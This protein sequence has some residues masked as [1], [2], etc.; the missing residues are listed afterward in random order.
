MTIFNASYHLSAIS[1]HTKMSL[2]KRK[3]NKVTLVLG[4][5]SARGIAHIGVLE[6]LHREGMHFDLIIGTSIGSII[7]AMYS[8]NMNIEKAKKF[9]LEISF[10]DIIDVAIPR[11]GFNRGKKLKML[12]DRILEGRGFQDLKIPL[13]VVATD[14]ANGQTVIY[15]SG[16]LNEV[17]TASCSIPVIYEPV[18][19]KGRSIVDGGIK[20]TVPVAIAR[21]L[22]ADFIIASDV[23]FCVKN[24]L[25]GNIFQVMMQSYQIQGQALSDYQSMDAEIIIKPDLGEIDQMAFEKAGECIEKGRQAAEKVLRK[26]KR[27]LS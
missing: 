7:G 8:L 14:I 18:K 22:G 24:S 15:K 21:E 16:D 26:I 12:I 9:A 5:G 3:P 27:V 1:I 4:G 10:R 19:I 23:G 25:P 17:I 6:V 20:N 13:A 11:L 2:F